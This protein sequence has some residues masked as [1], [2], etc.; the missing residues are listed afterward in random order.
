MCFIDDLNTW[1]QWA[2]Y[3]LT[4]AR[5][6]PK[7]KLDATNMAF[8]AKDCDTARQ[9][10]L[11]LVCAYKHNIWMPGSVEEKQHKLQ[12]FKTAAST[13]GYTFGV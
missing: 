1:S 7:E 5:I 3:H 6:Y 11:V 8:A 4:P 10:L 13:I 2:I 12:E 9:I